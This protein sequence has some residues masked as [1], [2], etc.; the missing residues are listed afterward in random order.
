M[1]TI[2]QTVW[3]V[4]RRGDRAEAAAPSPNGNEPALAAP[5]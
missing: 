3:K 4:I 5:A 1:S 2:T